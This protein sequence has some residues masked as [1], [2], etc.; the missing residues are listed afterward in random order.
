MSQPDLGG[1][2]VPELT[3][4][5]LGPPRVERDGAPVQVDTRKAIALLAYLAMSGERLGRDLVAGM[6]WPDADQAHARAALRRTLTVTGKALGGGWLRADRVTVWLD[7]DGCRFDVRRFRELLR[8]CGGHGHPPQATCPRCADPLAEAV[9]LHRGEFMAGFA[10]RDADTFEEWQGTNADALGRELAGALE[11]LVAALLAAGSLERAL[12]AA[13]RWLLL[14][15]L[16]EPAHRQ[17]MRLYAWSGQRAA[18]LRQYR[19][20]VRILDEELGVAPLTETTALYRAITEERLEPPPAPPVTAAPAAAGPPARAPQPPLVGRAAAWASLVGAFDGAGAGGRLVVLEGEAGV[21]KTRLAEALAA[22]AAARDAAVIARAC[23]EEE[24][25]LA[26]GPFVEALRAAPPGWVQR[27]PT[28]WLAE[29]ARLLPELATGRPGQA[30]PDGPS[31]RARFLEGLRQALLAAT[32]GPEPGLLLLDDLHWAD[33]ASVELLTYLVRRL[34][35]WPCCVLLTW[36]GDQVPRGHPL[37]RLAREAQRAGVATV[38]RLDRLGEADVAELV[39]A[40]A[41]ERA[42][43]AAWLYRETEGLP[44]FLVEYLAAGAPP[45]GSLPEGVRDLLAARAA[46]AGETG[47]QLLTAA[48]VIGRSFDVGILRQASGRGDEE[49][50]AALEEL[51]VRGLVREVGEAYDF[52][53]DKLRA[54]VYE[55]AGL[56]RRRLL[57]RRVAEALA[58]R[59]RGRDPA[60]LAAVVGRHLQLAGEEGEAAGWFRRAGDHARA[61]FANREALA[62]YQAA[63]A[64]GHRDAGG[65]HEALGDLHTLQGDYDAAR[66]SYEAAAARA[67]GG[68]LAALEHK[69]GSLHHRMGEWDAA[70]SHFAAAAALAG[71]DGDAAARARLHADWSLTLRR[72]GQADQ[73]LEQAEQALALAEAAGDVQALAQAYNILGILAGGLGDRDGARRHLERSLALAEALPDPSARIAAL[74]NLA[75]ACRAAGD[76][77]R[78]LDLTTSALA[79][80]ASQGDRHREA[81]LHSNLADL[82][83]AAG[84]PDQAIAHLK[85]AAAIFAQVGQPERLQPEIWKLVEW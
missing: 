5:L 52:T 15:P 82:L 38:L 81:A 11:R 59:A 57:H 25:G 6:L 43:E 60:A 65:L 47:W 67:R 19:D 8:D 40:V 22:H 77:E 14:D 53:H 34:A 54:F 73:A 3:L 37:R 23:Y 64:L 33:Q 18:A 16:H 76:L 13:H 30:A 32:A 79:L 69:L 70:D 41:P 26:F 45:D 62:H 50:V 83:H 58:R 46:A 75:L 71:R 56:A 51:T 85:Q 78:S 4:A 61:V 17:L 10:L 29:V 39:G 1:N 7:A 80:C 66:S 74:N 27:L 12:E 48:A 9:A 68:G 24:L 84:R 42:G 72:R 36:R 20:C 2:R 35:E 31:A 55:E 21:G 63:L 49:T 28:H 44:F